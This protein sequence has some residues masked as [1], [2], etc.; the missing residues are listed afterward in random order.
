[1]SVTLAFVTDEW[2]MCAI[3]PTCTQH[4]GKTTGQDLPNVVKRA[5][6]ARSLQEC[7]TAVMRDCELSMVKAGR[8]IEEDGV[9]NPMGFIFHCLQSS[10]GVVFQGSEVSV[11]LRRAG[12]TMAWY[13]GSS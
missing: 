5:I 10:A 7:I 9:V 4:S 8:V 1:M 3:S 2:E 6:N 13:K 11:T 12:K